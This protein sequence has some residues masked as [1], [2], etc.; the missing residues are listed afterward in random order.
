MYLP[1][2]ISLPS[3]V[4]MVCNIKPFKLGTPIRLYTGSAV[5]VYAVLTPS[6]D[7]G[8]LNP[9]ADISFHIDGMLVGRFSSPSPPAYVYNA[10]VYANSSL[11]LDLHTISIINGEQNVIHSLFMLDK[12]MYRYLPNHDLSSP[13]ILILLSFLPAPYPMIPKISGPCRHLKQ[14]QWNLEHPFQPRFHLRIS[15]LLLKAIPSRQGP[16]LG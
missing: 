5:Y 7:L 10:L 11:S 15:S 3:L 1:I 16:S 8:T 12:I 14:I 13:L 9:P 4:S 2:K 6:F